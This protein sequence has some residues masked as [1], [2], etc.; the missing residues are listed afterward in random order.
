[1]AGLLICWLLIC[2]D[3]GMFNAEEVYDK[4]AAI[5]RP[6]KSDNAHITL[7]ERCWEQQ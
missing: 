5:N 3:D 4:A 2:L 1:M 7:T 6:I